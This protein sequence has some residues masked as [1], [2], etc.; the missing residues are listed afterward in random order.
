MSNNLFSLMDRFAQLKVLVIG[1]AMLDRYLKGST[2]RLSQEAPVLVVGVEEREDIPGG[3]GNTAV[4][5]RCLGAQPFYLSVMGDDEEGRSLREALKHYDI[6]DEH[7]LSQAGRKTLAKQRVLA[8]DQMMI[9]FDQGSTEPL[10]SEA[11]EWVINHLTELAP[12][13]DAII[14]SDYAYGMFTPRIL[15]AL[16]A[17]QASQPHLLFVDAK[18]LKP[19]QSMR[20]TA[21]KPNYSEAIK[22]LKLENKD[23]TE[24]RIKQIQKHGAKI[25]DI[26]H[27]Q[28][29]AVTLDKD[30]AYIFERGQPCYR[31][32][33]RPAAH[34]RVAGAGDTFISAMTLALAA[35]AQTAAAAEIASTAAAIVVEK[36]GTSACHIE[37]LKGYFSTGEKY[38][39]DN[40][41]MAAL[42]AAYR[43][44]GKRLVFTNGCFD[45]LHS[46]HI[47]YLNQAKANG[48]VLIVGINTDPGVKRLK[49]PNRPINPLEDRVQVLAGLSC[50][51][52]IIPFDEDIPYNL[53][54]MIQPHVFVKG[55]D[56]SLN[57][58]PEAALV[59]ELGGEVKILP[60]IENHSTTGIIERIRQVYTNPESKV[61]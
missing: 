35:G 3:A 49:G 26:A 44:Q 2:N 34:N 4:N 56:Y 1:E 57:T 27:S 22:M 53:I 28:I 61:G 11:E 41:H 8:N 43:H 50:V 46:G 29:A 32:Y 17:L 13:M 7:I 39:T 37:E 18:N 40:F 38:I 45:I 36:P 58:L 59:Q 47:T 9:R 15:N 55:G 48:E 20:V 21:V 31:I 19:Y 5:I 14:V 10:D 42:V 51:D 52:H 54:R 25:L 23:L 24:D 6:S 30:G 60:Y 12:I 16:A 33:A